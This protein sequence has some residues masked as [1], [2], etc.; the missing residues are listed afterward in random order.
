MSSNPFITYFLIETNKLKDMGIPLGNGTDNDCSKTNNSG[1]ANREIAKLLLSLHASGTSAPPSSELA[2]FGS[3]NQKAEDLSVRVTNNGNNK[4]Y[5]Q[6]NE[7]ALDLTSSSNNSKPAKSISMTSSDSPYSAPLPA[8]ISKIVKSATSGVG[9]TIIDLTGGGSMASITKAGS[10]KYGSSNKAPTGNSSLATVTVKPSSKLQQIPQGLQ[11][12]QSSATATSAKESN[13]SQAAAAAAAAAY[14]FY[15]QLASMANQLSPSTLSNLDKALSSNANYLLQNLL[16]G[17]IG[18]M[19][20][21]ATGGTTSSSAAS[22]VAST[23]NSATLSLPA[24]SLPTQPIPAQA[25]TLPTIPVSIKPPASVLKG[26]TTNTIGLSSPT[27]L[28]NS[29]LSGVKFSN[30]Q[31]QPT[32]ASSTTSTNLAT[33]SNNILAQISSSTSPTGSSNA[34]PLQLVEG[35]TATNIPLLCGQIVAQ[36]NG[37]LF[38]VHGLNNSTIELNLQ[39][40]LIAIYTRLQEVVAMVEQAKNQQQ[41]NGIKKNEVVISSQKQ[42]KNGNA[43]LTTIN[44]TSNINNEMIQ[45]ELEKIKDG[46]LKEEEKIA[47]HIEEYRRQLIQQQN[48]NSC[49]KTGTTIT[50]IPATSLPSTSTVTL[51]GAT[52]NLSALTADSSVA[53]AAA[54]AMAAAVQ[55]SLAGLLK[56]QGALSES[57]NE[58]ITD[59]MQQ[60][61]DSNSLL[62][63]QQERN[64]DRRRGRPPKGSTGDLAQVQYLSS[65]CRVSAMF[66]I[67]WIC[68]FMIKS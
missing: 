30:N 66:K 53:A 13:A 48:I 36:L 60:E 20:Q 34:N 15:P 55:N 51:S 11:I 37:L 64:K 49:L 21:N 24:S 17:K 6:S 63:T 18:Q 4:T 41:E 61:A 1:E 2:A 67:T 33:A 68:Y 9:N 16:L 54:Q 42:G 38:L 57:G 27:N 10:A 56:P 5:Q 7:M 50:P 39:Q 12:N 44:T 32:L 28:L 47:K 62:L 52:A 31:L 14:P 46:K 40:Q 25:L 43:N 35:N 29:Q 3:D 22:P 58:I 26:T 45:R 59:Q 19:Q 23:A 8:S 65:Y